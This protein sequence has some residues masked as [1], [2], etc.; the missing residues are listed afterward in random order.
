MKIITCNNNDIKINSYVLIENN[1]AIVIDPY[2]FNEIEQ[3]IS[4]NTLDYILLTHE[5]FDHISA[6]EKLREKYNIK[7]VGQELTSKN[8]QSSKKNLSK[9]SRVILDYMQIVPKAPIKSLQVRPADIVFQNDFKLNWQ[10]HTFVFKHTPGHSEGS[11]CIYVE[12]YLFVGDSL[13]ECCETDVKGSSASRK[14]YE[15]ITIPFLN[16]FNKSMRVYSGH[17]NSFLLGDK[18][19]AKQRALEIFKNRCKYTNCYVNFNTFKQLLNNSDFFVR[20]E[21]FFIVQKEENF[22]R[23]YYYVEKYENLTNLDSFFKMYKKPIVLEMVS[24]NTIEKKHYKNIGFDLYKTY[25]RYFIAANTKKAKKLKYNP[26]ELANNEDIETIKKMIDNAFDPLSDY[27][28]DY[29][30]LKNF[31]KKDEIYVVKINQKIAGTAI[32]EKLGKNY[33]FRL[34]CVDKKYRNGF[35]GY[36]LASNLLSENTNYKTWIDDE[37]S[38]A[39]NLNK[40]IGYRQDGLKNY[41]FVKKHLDIVKEK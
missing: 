11:A 12:R 18:I 30:A 9:F 4:L 7:V 16:S 24:Q 20:D 29:E 1:H 26:I 14:D 33:Y 28:P 34:S 37:N 19:N 22:Y 38:L 23:F 27:I 36:I 39:I 40:K 8:I 6:V 10:G 31:I 15:N 17:Y 3:A 35:I 41:I 25:S 13:F 2:D 5:H 32:Y 21:S